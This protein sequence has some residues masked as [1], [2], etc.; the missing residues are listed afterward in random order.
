MTACGRHQPGAQCSTGLGVPRNHSQL[1]VTL[2]MPRGVSKRSAGH[3]ASPSAPWLK[4]LSS[5]SDSPSIH[6]DPSVAA[7]RILVRTAGNLV[8]LQV[9]EPAVL[10]FPTLLRDGVQSTQILPIS[11][12]IANP[13]TGAVTGQEFRIADPHFRP[14]RPAQS[15]RAPLSHFQ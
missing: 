10:A 15:Y 13:E 12:M 3:P 7:K 1:V 14:H 5:K 6:L 2:W 11:L 4:F 8:S 9:R